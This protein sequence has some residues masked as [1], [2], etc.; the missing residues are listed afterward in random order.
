MKVVEQRL[1]EVE[2][3]GERDWALLREEALSTL[4][5]LLH[6]PPSTPPTPTNSGGRPPITVNQEG[7]RNRQQ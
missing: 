7:G 2:A 4:G 6:H 1:A 5:V 3:L